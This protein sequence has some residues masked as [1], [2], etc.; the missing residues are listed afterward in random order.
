[1]Y[2]VIDTETTGLSPAHRHR[3]IE[4]A[5]VLLDPAGASSTSG[6]PC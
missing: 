3:V 6:S 1:V 4:I 5:V 2:A